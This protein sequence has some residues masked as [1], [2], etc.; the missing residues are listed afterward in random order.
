MFS[1]HITTLKDYILDKNRYFSAGY[2]NAV[3]TKQGIYIEKS[4]KDKKVVF[5]DDKSGDYFY[6]R[7]D[8]KA[9]F[10]E[11]A[12][13]A[14]TQAHNTGVM[15]QVKAHIIAIVK[16]ADAETLVNNLISTIIE[17]NREATFQDMNWSKEEI[18]K[19]ELSLL[20]EKDV[21]AAL[22]RIKDATIVRVA[23]TYPVEVFYKK[24]NCIT[25]PCTCS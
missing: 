3:R 20:P 18:T 21:D 24:T 8:T 9:P 17:K 4:A 25:N 2:A 15:S 6:I 13:F 5:P 10:A 19:D 14:L 11:S 16:Q 22:A 23:F 1:T 12:R 7:L